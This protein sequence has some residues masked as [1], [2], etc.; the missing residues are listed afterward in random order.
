[1]P[2]TSIIIRTFNEERH[3]PALLNAIDRQQY[4]DYETIVVD[5]G[6]YDRTQRIAE[7]RADR[8]VRIQPDDFTFGHSLNVG[9]AASAGDILVMVSAHTEPTSSDWLGRLVEALRDPKVAMVYG[10]QVGHATSKFSETRDFSRMFGPEG[11]VMTPPKWFANNAN[12][13]I[14]RSL[15]SRHPFDETLPGLEDIEWAKYWMGQGYRVLY[16]PEAG[17]YHIHQETWAQ[18]RRRYYREGQAA[19]WIGIRGRRDVPRAIFQEAG[20]CADDLLT[21]SR[22]GR[23]AEKA[24]EIL[25]FRHEK[26]AGTVGGIWDGAFMDNPLTKRQ[27]FFDRT[28]QAVVIEGPGRAALRHVERPP[29]RPSEVLVRVAF[30]GVCA[31]DLEVLDGSLGYY[32]TGLARYP[33]VPGHEFSGTVA[34]VGGRVTDLKEGDSVVVECIQGCGDCEECRRG[35]W[36]G[37]RERREVGVMGRNGGYAEY[38]VTARRFVHA[39]PSNVELRAACLCEPVA[40]VLK[41]LRRLERL[42]GSPV[43]ARNCAVVG[44]GPIGHLAARLLAL[45]GHRVTVLDPRP[46]R[47][48]LFGGTAIAAG[49]PLAPLTSFDTLI[50][51][52]GHPGALHRV[53]QESGA[54]STI[55]LFGFPYAEQPFNF[56]TIVGYDKTV[57]GSVGSAAEDFHAALAVLPRLDLSPFVQTVLP[58][59]D[60]ADAWQLTRNRTHLKVLLDVAGRSARDL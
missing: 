14:L 42:G 58:L 2:E 24:I 21:V 13:A 28:Y 48:A 54:G 39:L 36:I 31:T 27:L 22:E 15:W 10:R 44:A 50:E 23:F 26:L 56:E 29:L 25:R 33:I 60:F 4:R 40:V 6:S 43:Q 52:T 3:L 20:R 51:A 59:K 57:M 49:D 32:K 16:V 55:L 18:V 30:Q 45:Q 5:S 1:M 11:C 46:D 17:V 7:A 8:L 47:L 35:N 38:M 12:A 37:C 9:I 41:G 53:L 34:A 19:K